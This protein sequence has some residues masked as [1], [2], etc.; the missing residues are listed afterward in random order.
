[1]VV[2]R[3]LITDQRT[4]EFDHFIY[5][6]E[7]VNK[8]NQIAIIDVLRRPIVVDKIVPPPKDSGS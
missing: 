7:K 2:D 8:Q 6:R 3:H 1:M 4:L 5:V